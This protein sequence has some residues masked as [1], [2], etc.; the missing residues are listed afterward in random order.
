MINGE[1]KLFLTKIF[2]KL[3]DQVVNLTIKYGRFDVDN[4]LCNSTTIS[5]NLASGYAI[6]L[7]KLQTILR[8]EYSTFPFGLFFTTDS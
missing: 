2:R 1:G 3:I 4:L 5:K 7:K 6:V 8:N